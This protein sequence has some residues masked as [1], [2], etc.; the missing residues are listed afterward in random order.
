MCVYIYR[1]YIRDVR[2]LKLITLARPHP[3]CR[4]ILST[5]TTSIQCLSSKSAL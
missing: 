2:E 5:Q 3:V 1:M 4:P